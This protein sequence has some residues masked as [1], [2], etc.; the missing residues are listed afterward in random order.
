LEMAEIKGFFCGVVVLQIRYPRFESGRG[1][2]LQPL[3]I[4]LIRSQTPFRISTSGIRPRLRFRR[5]ALNQSQGDA[6]AIRFLCKRRVS[7]INGY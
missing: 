6:S 3:A 2:F 1:L 4:A 5:P 7:A